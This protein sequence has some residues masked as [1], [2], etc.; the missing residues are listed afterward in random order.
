MANE[1]GNLQRKIHLTLGLHVVGSILLVHVIVYWI[2]ALQDAAALITGLMLGALV[3]VISGGMSARHLVQPID[4]VALQVRSMVEQRDFSQ[5]LEPAAASELGGMAN[6]INHLLETVQ[7][8]LRE[9]GR[10]STRLVQDARD[11]SD[12]SA[13]ASRQMSPQA[14]EQLT[15]NARELVTA[16]DGIVSV[17]HQSEEITVKTKE[18]A[19]DGAL[20][21]V[22]AMCSIDKLVAEIDASA[23][24]VENMEADSTKIGV[25]L[26]V[27]K[28]IAD[29]TNLL[30]LNAAIEAARAGEHG[31]GFSVVA[32][33]VRT[34][35]SR[36]AES[37][38][39]I[40]KIISH[41]QE[42]VR[43]AVQKIRQTQAGG[44]A[45]ALEAEKAAEALSEVSGAV[46][47][48]HDMYNQIAAATQKQSAV[49]QQLQERVAK[50]VHEAAGAHQNLQS[51]QQTDANLS[52]LA[53]EFSKLVQQTARS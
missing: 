45:G 3:A 38:R 47:D 14:L 48:I 2:L 23:Q 15:H 37:T 7:C 49:S 26:D 25:V 4:T 42:G 53:A 5:R 44:Q 21:T 17:I 36:T 6:E 40:Q 1:N 9:F 33:E 52:Q 13:R 39:E 20:V 46:S 27:I 11:F 8:T 22:N 31:R 16:G 51:M 41:L 28:S 32:D 12:F 19:R 50:L 29:Q 24:T 43:A 10:L 34:L 18:L 35:A 30:A